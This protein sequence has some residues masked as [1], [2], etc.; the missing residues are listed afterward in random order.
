M[1]SAVVVTVV[2]MLPFSRVSEKE[3]GVREVYQGKKKFN[4]H[5]PPL[6]LLIN[7]NVTPSPHD[8]NL[9][10]LLSL[11]RK[12]GQIHNEWTICVLVSL[13]LL[14]SDGIAY[15]HGLTNFSYMM[16]REKI[17]E[18]WS[19]PRCLGYDECG[20]IM[21]HLPF[22]INF[23]RDGVS[24]VFVFVAVFTEFCWTWW[25]GEWFFVFCSVIGHGLADIM[26]QHR[27]LVAINQMGNLRIVQETLHMDEDKWTEANTEYKNS[28]KSHVKDSINEK[29]IKPVQP[30]SPT[31]V[32]PALFSPSSYKKSFLKRILL[33]L[34]AFTSPLSI[35]CVCIF[36][37][38][39]V[40]N[41]YLY[42]GVLGKMVLLL[43]AHRFFAEAVLTF[44]R[45]EHLTLIGYLGEGSPIKRTV[46]TC[47]FDSFFALVGRLLL[48]NMGNDGAI[49]VNIFIMAVV[50]AGFR[51]STMKRDYW[52]M[53]RN[54]VF[55]KLME[56]K[57]EE[58]MNQLKRL[59]TSSIFLQMVL[60][61][62]SIIMSAL[63][64]FVFVKHRMVFDFGYPND[65][66]AI[67]SASLGVN[68]LYELACEIG[69]SVVTIL[70]LQQHEMCSFA[71]ILDDIDHHSLFL[72]HFCSC[73]TALF[74]ALIAFKSV[75]VFLFCSDNDPCSCPRFFFVQ[76]EQYCE[77]T[78]VSEETF[79]SANL[80]DSEEESSLN[81]STLFYVLLGI[82]VLLI[83]SMAAAFMMNKSKQKREA[84]ELEIMKKKINDQQIDKEKMAMV[85]DVLGMGGDIPSAP[86][87]KSA[88]S[89]KFILKVENFKE[90]LQNNKPQTQTQRSSVRRFDSVTVSP[91]SQA[92]KADATVRKAETTPNNP[93]GSPIQT[94]SS[95]H[96]DPPPDS[97]KAGDTERMETQGQGQGQGEPMYK[98]AKSFDFVASLKDGGKVNI[99]EEEQIRQL[100]E[101]EKKHL[102]KTTSAVLKSLQIDSEEIEI[103]QYGIAKGAFGEIHKAN[104]NGQTVALKTLLHLEEDSLLLFKHEILLSAQLQH[105]NV[106][107]LIGA[108]WD[109]SMIALVLEF[110]EGGSLDVALKKNFKRGW[111]WSD[112]LLKIVIDVASALEFMH[113]T[114]FYDDQTQTLQD[115]ILHR[116]MKPSNVLL[117]SSL[118]AKLADFGTSKAIDESAEQT[119]VGTPIFMAP[120]IY[121]G[122]SYD[123]SADVFSFG[124]SM[125]A[126]SVGHDKLFK[127]L[128][129]KLRKNVGSN[130]AAVQKVMSAIAMDDL[131]PSLNEQCQVNMPKSLKALIH[132]C[133]E[134]NKRRRPTMPEVLATLKTTVSE[135]IEEMYKKNLR[136]DVERDAHVLRKSPSSRGTSPTQ[137]T[138]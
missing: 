119:I 43:V 66:G 27:K 134:T 124:M 96:V 30:P 25:W 107:L 56:N 10:D 70:Y 51:I 14:F 86:E 122:G 115:T 110:A 85:L 49:L 126:I 76:Y 97:P 22:K 89:V 16:V 63:I 129:R 136:F 39:V 111:N 19:E 131:R 77:A 100:E 137:F 72:G 7:S 15:Y 74:G 84:K 12:S 113:R 104:Y 121:Q 132:L 133:W 6:L 90:F 20:R 79:E 130:S 81:T 78:A 47:L 55:R 105:P 109:R 65:G 106:I 11:Q 67:N 48:T 24:L 1:V 23:V 52:V 69:V 92:R 28:P 87:M 21:G 18:G 116:D 64:Y 114:P 34:K 71:Q 36:Y 46:K 2:S 68:K 31:T 128:I 75:P 44:G 108:C 5:P 37:S 9:S 60:E 98:S 80:G 58:T 26:I 120:E 61:S 29:E 91:G 59:G 42:S 4:L 127:R 62:Y 83:N 41:A 57:R 95:S 38:L 8:P 82:V 50:Q 54:K 94:K 123:H 125:W 13:A 99:T 88:E 45:V 33:A 93:P 3:F 40:L 103:L 138:G 102:A 17:G 53:S 135:D 112:P 32:N 118:T 101:D 117:T 35:V 73:M